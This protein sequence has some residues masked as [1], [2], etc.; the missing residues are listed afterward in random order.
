M[1]IYNG[2]YR[3]ICTIEYTRHSTQKEKKHKQKQHNT[4]NERMFSTNPNKIILPMVS[5]PCLLQL[6]IYK[7]TM[8]IYTIV[9]IYL[10]VGTVF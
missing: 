7:L 8:L 3:D 9:T 6:Q 4:E 2:L 5:S 10:S 1:A